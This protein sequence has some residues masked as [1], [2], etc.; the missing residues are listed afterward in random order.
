MRFLSATLRTGTGFGA[1]ALGLGGF[2]KDRDRALEIWTPLFSLLP[3]VQISP[4]KR[5]G[6]NNGSRLERSF[7]TC[8]CCAAV[9]AP[10][11]VRNVKFDRTTAS[12]DKAHRSDASYDFHMRQSS[13]VF[14]QDFEAK[15]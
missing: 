15:K 7:M 11:G 9:C 4:T 14:K 13:W 8:K 10:F 6:G 5:R 1:Q 2:P 3:G 12:W